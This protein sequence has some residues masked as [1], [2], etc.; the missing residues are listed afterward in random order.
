V[1]C[2]YHEIGIPE[3]AVLDRPSDVQTIE[4]VKAVLRRD[5]KL[6]TDAQIS[7][8]MPLIGGEFDLDSLDILLLVTSIEKE[9][10]VRMRDKEISRD[11]FKSV[12]SLAAFVDASRGGS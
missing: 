12:A 3:G 10:G 5:L 11:A 8:D 9:F 4:T 7:D 2:W 1:F 6:G